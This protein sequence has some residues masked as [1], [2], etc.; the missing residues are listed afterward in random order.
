MRVDSLGA[1]WA[2]GD[3]V[4]AIGQA[5]AQT[6]NPVRVKGEISSFTRA[7]SGH[8]YFSLKDARGQIRCAMF[9]RAAASLSRFPKEGDQVEVTGRLDV[10]APR[11]DL[12]LVVETLE[13]AG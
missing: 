6:F 8:C 10:Y 3:L 2:V 9:K 4:G 1:A 7:V 13:T 12:Q 5:V 11:G